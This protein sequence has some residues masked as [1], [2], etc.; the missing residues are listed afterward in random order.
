M[1]SDGQTPTVTLVLAILPWVTVDLPTSEP[2]IP[3]DAVRSLLCIPT[4]LYRVHRVCL[5]VRP[6]IAVAVRAVFFFRPR[7]LTLS[8][9]VVVVVVVAVVVVVKR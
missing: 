8:V 3:T 5:P 2:R 7:L 4:S 9:V 6:P 1:A